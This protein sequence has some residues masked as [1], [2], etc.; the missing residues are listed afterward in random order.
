MANIQTAQAIADTLLESIRTAAQVLLNTPSSTVVGNVVSRIE[1]AVDL[2][3]ISVTRFQTVSDLI[4]NAQKEG[5]D[6]TPAEVGVAEGF[7]DASL[8]SVKDDLK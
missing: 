6:L 1:A 2:L 8:Q 7:Y 4:K 3:A 5:R